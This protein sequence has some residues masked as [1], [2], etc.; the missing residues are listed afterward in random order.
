MSLLTP[1]YNN[2]ATG[3]LAAAVINAFDTGVAGGGTASVSELIESAAAEALGNR[4]Q[5]R[6]SA[7]Q[8]QQVT[9]RGSVAYTNRNEQRGKKRTRSDEI[10]RAVAANLCNV[11][12]QCKGLGKPFQYG[13]YSMSKYAFSDGENYVAMPFYAVDL[14][15]TNNYGQ[16]SNVYYSN[17][18]FRLYWNR[19]DSKAVWRPAP[20]TNEAGQINPVSDFTKG[21]TNNSGTQNQGQ[22]R[23]INYQANSNL[24]SSL[25]P[26]ARDYI[27]SIDIYLNLFAA[28]K[29]PTRFKVDVVRLPDW[30]CPYNSNDSSDRLDNICAD[31]AMHDAFWANEMVT[32]T[33][34][35]LA[36]QR[37]VRD[38]GQPALLY[39]SGAFKSAYKGGM[40]SYIGGPKFFNFDPK[41]DSI[42]DPLSGGA[43]AS[44]SAARM[45]REKITLN[46]EREVDLN[47]RQRTLYNTAA[48]DVLKPVVAPNDANQD[49]LLRNIDT[50]TLSPKP[51]ERMYLIIQSTDFVESTGSTPFSLT[52]CPFGG[53]TDGSVSVWGCRTA[54]DTIANGGLAGTQAATDFQYSGSFDMNIIKLCRRL[55]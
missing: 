49:T 53:A 41:D 47:Y 19:T 40:Y 5:T 30:A 32:W 29:Y 44:K 23:P 26:Y 20:S 22:W 42:Q 45:H 21:S 52:N 10:R 6:T 18:V 1:N 46:L 51:E 4:V 25:Y 15:S 2:P 27:K 39:Q 11:Y 33:V 50:Y 37:G 3:A 24:A 14:T 8:N 16:G 38:G 12:W 55:N 31:P 17:P 36:V 48:A 54:S 9:L 28:R 43:N 34:H 13:F 35:P 7:M